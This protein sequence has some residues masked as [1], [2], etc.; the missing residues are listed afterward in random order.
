MGIGCV[1][2]DEDLGVGLR[3]EVD[4]VGGEMVE[5]LEVCG[6]MVVDCE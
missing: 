6:G 5:Y 1:S 4:E 2:E 3:R